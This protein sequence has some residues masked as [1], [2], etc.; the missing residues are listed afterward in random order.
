MVPSDRVTLAND[1]PIASEGRY[2]LYWMISAR[3][4]RWSF[5]LDRALAMARHLRKPLLVLEAIRLHHRWASQRTHRFVVEGMAEQARAFEAAGVTYHAYVESAHGVER[6]L[7]EELAEDACMV[8][9]DL[10]PCFFLPSMVQRAAARLQVRLEQVDGNGL[11]PISAVPKAFSTA[12]TFRRFLH[13]TLPRHLQSWPQ[14]DPLA[15][16]DLGRVVLP[17]KVPSRWPHAASLLEDPAR[18]SQLPLQG[19]SP[20]PYRGGATE[21]ERALDRFLSERL[22]DYEEHNHPDRE[23][24]SGLSPYLHFGHISAHEVVHRVLK[25]EDWSIEDLGPVTGSREGWWGV[26]AAAES[27]LDECVTWREVGYSFCAHERGY[28]RFDTLP[29]WALATLR[30]HRDDPRS[31]TYDLNQLAAAETGDPLWNAAQRQLLGEGRIHNYLRMLWGKKVLEWSP[32]PEEAWERLIEL[33]NRFAIDGRGPNSYTGIA[34]TFGRF[35][36]A[37]GPER[38]IYGTVRYMTS[39]STRRKLDLERWSSRWGG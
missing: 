2:V 26:S 10:F 35:D 33:N 7:L 27:F 36:R 15:G 25:H 11:L 31:T 23:V 29:A 18:V 22:S 1:R 8:V 3:R 38:P 39:D 30:Q 21:A 5:A 4:T 9:T 32:S 20:V 16:Y 28:D 14:S 34:W 37:W 6:G 19:P 24:G 12:H 13:Q 17:A